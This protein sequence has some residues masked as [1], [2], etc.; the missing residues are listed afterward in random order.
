MDISLQ[1][2]ETAILDTLNKLNS[3]TET[4][5]L[6]CIN[7]ICIKISEILAQMPQKP[8]TVLEI[9]LLQA[10]YEGPRVFVIFFGRF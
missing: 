10:A 2:T 4:P 7:P 5:S 1:K 6:N 3:F 9:Q 8:R